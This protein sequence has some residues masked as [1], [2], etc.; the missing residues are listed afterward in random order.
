MLAYGLGNAVEDGWNEQLWK[1]GSVDQHIES[2]LRPELS[3]GWL[4][5]LAGAAAIYAFWFR[6]ARER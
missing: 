6:P 1:R 2:V 5:I 4:T 3:V